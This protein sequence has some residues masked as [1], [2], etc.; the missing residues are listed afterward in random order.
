MKHIFLLACIFFLLL[1]ACS[2]SHDPNWEVKSGRIV[3][4]QDAVIE[5]SELVKEI[6]PQTGSRSSLTALC[7]PFF[8]EQDISRPHK[9]G[10]RISRAFWGRWTQVGLFPTMLFSDAR[11]PG[12]KKALAEAR[13]KNIDLLVRGQIVHFLAGGSTG[14][15][16]L[17]LRIDIYAV[18]SGLP[19]WSLLQ[20]GRIAGAPDRDYILTVRRTRMPE[21]AEIPLVMNLADSMARPILKWE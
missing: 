18:E 13:Q 17:G 8:M 2:S 14:T 7:Y 9:T 15:T 20:S 6:Y 11:W 21:A 5:L 10:Q 16:S 12:K 4:Y 19:V 1:P 3:Q